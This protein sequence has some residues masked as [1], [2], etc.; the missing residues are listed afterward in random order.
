MDKDRQWDTQREWMLNT[1][2]WKRTAEQLRS[3]AV[4][5]R[6][7]D[8]QDDPPVLG[9]SG[10]SESEQDFTVTVGPI[11]HN[12]FIANVVR[13]LM[14]FSLENLL[15]ALIVAEKS[16]GVLNSKNELASWGCS[17]H[18][19]K[20]LAGQAKIEMSPE[21]EDYCRVWEMCAVW[22]GRY[23]VPLRASDLPDK[24]DF[25]PEPLE[26]LAEKLRTKEG[27]ARFMELLLGKTAHDRLA[28]H[29]C[30]PEWRAYL[31]LFD[32][33]EA[34]RSAVQKPATPIVHVYRPSDAEPE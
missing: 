23:P 17:W 19:L 20:G 10:D 3:A 32:R 24:P 34:R 21:E 6:E 30:D 15:K 28:T 16:D 18:D 4:V 2:S 33:L 8:Q 14:G 25:F 7:A 11:T 27:I 12:G 5:L 13:M 31:G 1:Y 26:E 22:A 29:V 9:E